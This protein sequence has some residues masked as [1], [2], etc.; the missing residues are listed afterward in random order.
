MDERNTSPENESLANRKR[1]SREE[2]QRLIEELCGI[3]AG[4]PSMCDE[5]LEERRLERE[6]ELAEDGF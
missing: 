4:G 2:A 3:C 6:R 1:I 5:L